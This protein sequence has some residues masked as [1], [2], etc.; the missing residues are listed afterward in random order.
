MMKIA[1]EI[2]GTVRDIA[3]EP[4]AIAL[5]PTEALTIG[6]ARD[7][8]V[9]AILSEAPSWAFPGIVTS[10]EIFSKPLMDIVRIEYESLGFQ[11][12]LS[13]TAKS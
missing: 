2:S 3:E 10:S 8:A 4:V 1:I 13:V 6:S 11:P 7:L 12:E 5:Q 9:T